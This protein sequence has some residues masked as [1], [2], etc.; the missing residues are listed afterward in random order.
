MNPQRTR[1]IL[2]AAAAVLVAQIGLSQ[3]LDREEYLPETPPLSLLP[4]QVDDYRL[5]E[6][7]EVEESIIARL[8]PDDILNRM[9]RAPGRPDLNFFMSYYRTQHRAKN[10]H[11]PKVCLPG[12]GWN[13]TASRT[14]DLTSPGSPVPV[15]A[16]YY[17]I[18]RGVNKAVVIYWFQTQRGGYAV[19]QSL[20]IARVFQTIVDKRT[21]MALVRVVVPVFEGDE[22]KAG[23]QAIEFARGIYPSVLSYFQ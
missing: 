9:Y 7:I 10:A 6:E 18:S 2:L 13:P 3:F 1:I 23:K 4:V 17:V 5:A 14:F 22:A 20:K 11:D 16:N 8:G 19:E 12:S 21:D 15:T